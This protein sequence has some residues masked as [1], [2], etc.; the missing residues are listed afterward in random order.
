MKLV[1]KLISI[2]KR[3]LWGGN[4]CQATQKKPTIDKFLLLA[5]QL[6]THTSVVTTIAIV[7]GDPDG[8]DEDN[9]DGVRRVT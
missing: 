1:A 2:L 4:R 3:V 6:H 9:Q 7:L 5:D 8:G